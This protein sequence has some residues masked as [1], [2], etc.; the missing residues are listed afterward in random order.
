MDPLIIAEASVSSGWKRRDLSS[1]CEYSTGAG[2]TQSTSPVTQVAFHACR[3]VWRPRCRASAEM[4][5]GTAMD[6][7]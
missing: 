6:V 2:E 1:R 5:S 7:P 3:T 4:N